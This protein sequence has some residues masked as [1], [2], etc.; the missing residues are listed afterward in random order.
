MSTLGDTNMRETQIMIFKPEATS[1]TQSISRPSD[2]IKTNIGLHLEGYQEGN[3]KN[4][5]VKISIIKE[6]K[7]QNTDKNK[8]RNRGHYSQEKKRK[9]GERARKGNRKIERND[10][11]ARAVCFCNIRLCRSGVVCFKGRSSVVFTLC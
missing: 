7:R 2:I 1:L 4:G 10:A 8:R 5:R 6:K 3:N 11:S 9:N